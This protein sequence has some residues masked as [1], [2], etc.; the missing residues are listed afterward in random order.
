MRATSTILF[1]LL[2]TRLFAQMPAEYEVAYR[3]Y[4]V[5]I[6]RPVEGGREVGHGFILE[7]QGDSLLIATARHVVQDTATRSKPVAG[8]ISLYNGTT[9]LP[10][11]VVYLD[12]EDLAFI[13]VRAPGYRIEPAPLLRDAPMDVPLW[14]LSGRNSF[15]PYPPDFD[16]RLQ[17]RSG[18][19]RH[20][21][22]AIVGADQ[23]DSGSAIISH[24]GIVGI[25]LGGSDEV[26]CLNIGYI[27]E[28]HRSLTLSH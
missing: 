23:G 22:A 9:D 8:S 19:N 7:R 3:R 6:E 14:L 17:A 28:R 13:K 1:G 25:L 10:Y 27:M 16:G 12:K 20:F 5:L 21:W 24:G 15:R 4:V 18:N 11:H 26:R 2:L